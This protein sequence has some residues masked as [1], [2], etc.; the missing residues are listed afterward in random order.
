[1]LT[2]AYITA[3]VRCAPPDNKPLP[4]EIR[5][6]RPYLQSELE[7]LQRLLNEQKT[8]RGPSAL[9]E[10]EVEVLA[11]VAAGKSNRA[12]AEKLF[13]SPRTVEKHVEHVMD[14]L[15]VGSRAQIA[16]WYARQELPTGN[17]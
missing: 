17:R 3:A 8:G 9:S 14:K 7:L 2:D 12:I 6:C 15:G 11:L 13:L 4:E 5:L 10:R 1:M 16:A